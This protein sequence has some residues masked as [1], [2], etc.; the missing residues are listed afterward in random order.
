MG[1]VLQRLDSPMDTRKQMKNQFQISRAAVSN[2][3]KLI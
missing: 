1:G 3:L 2:Y